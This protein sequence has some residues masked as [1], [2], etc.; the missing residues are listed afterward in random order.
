MS[1]QHDDSY[2]TKRFTQRIGG[3]LHRVQTVTDET[4][5]IVARTLTPL[6]V[7]FGLRDVAQLI[8]GASALAIPVAYAEE[9]WRLGGELSQTN[10]LLIAL[11]SVSFLAVFAY[12]IFYRD[13]LPGHVHVFALRVIAAY[14][15]TFLVAA[16]SLLLVNR[17]PWASEPLLALN[18]AVIVAYPACFSA[19]VVDSIR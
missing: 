5:E 19:T 14:V 18:R 16:L 6:M 12:S 11:S 3:E 1:E 4:G 7:E 2:R 17:L 15:I 9:A 8:V 10:I 13:N